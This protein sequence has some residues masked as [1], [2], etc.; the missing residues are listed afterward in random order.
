MQKIIKILIWFLALFILIFIIATVIIALY[1]KKIVESQIEKNLNMETHLSSMSLSLPFTVNLNNLE[2]GKLFKADKILISPNI[3]SLFPKKLVLGKVVLVKPLVT[4]EQAEDGSL[5]I[6]KFTQKGA[7]PPVLITGLVIERGRFI[8]T[9]YKVKKEGLR[10]LLDNINA[11]ISKVTLPLNSLSA[12][13]RASAD[14]MNSDYKVIGS[15]MGKGNID[16]IRKHM[17]A[18]INIKDLDAAYFS[19]YYGDF[20]SKKKL[21]AAKLNFNSKLKAENNDLDINSKLR[22]SDLVYAETAQAEGE[23]PELNLT[24]DDLDLFTDEKGNLDLEF[25]IKTKFDN[26]SLSAEQLKKIILK[27]AA[28][29]LINAN[30]VTLMEK[31][32]QKLEQY[33]EI[34]KQL[35][36]IFK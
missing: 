23:L 33:K 17:D 36:N 28:K 6:P 9:D 21:L 34:G 10:V 16:F 14:I 1:G 27:A 30:P 7:Q 25:E 12:N 31:V 26:P 29:N 4:L 13:F 18:D 35:K 24:R 11:S 3:F 5:N 32:Q 2:V 20:I 8:F 15:A 22:L 19:P